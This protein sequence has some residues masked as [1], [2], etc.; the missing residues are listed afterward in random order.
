LVGA[1]NV[2]MSHEASTVIGVQSA[3]ELRWELAEARQ[4]QAAA[5]EVLRVIGE[6]ILGVLVAKR[7]F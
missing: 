2:L 1:L 7:G 6:D 5:T 4:G 3:E